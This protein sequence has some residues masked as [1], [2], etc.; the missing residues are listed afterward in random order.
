MAHEKLQPA[1]PSLDPTV[2]KVRP[3]VQGSFEI[4]GALCRLLGQH[5]G[6]VGWSRGI[7]PRD[8]PLD[9]VLEAVVLETRP[10]DAHRTCPCNCKSATHLAGHD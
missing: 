1:R 3:R 10:E 8:V 9:V 2:G 7:G 4:R 6:C 5:E